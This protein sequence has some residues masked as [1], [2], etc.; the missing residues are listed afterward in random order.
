M[1][2]LYWMRGVAQTSRTSKSAGFSLGIREQAA[3]LQ[4]NSALPAPQER[5]EED[6]TWLRLG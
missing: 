1:K 4:K 5:M 3:E 6:S 2:R